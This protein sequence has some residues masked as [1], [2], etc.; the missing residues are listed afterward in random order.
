MAAGACRGDG[1]DGR[2]I[3]LVV[4]EGGS[5]RAGTEPAIALQNAAQR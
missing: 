2:L 3:G 1:T 4:D 5:R